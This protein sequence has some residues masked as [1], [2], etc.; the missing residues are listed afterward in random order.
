[1]DRV[2]NHEIQAME[3]S[4]AG[5][6]NLPATFQHNDAAFYTRFAQVNAF[7]NSRDCQGVDIAK[8]LRDLDGQVV[9]VGSTFLVFRT[10]A[11]CQ[12]DK[13]WPLNN[14]LN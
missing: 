10:V 11:P 12:P 13:L 6:F 8:Q 14:D 7:G 2:V 4:L 5:F 9:Q 1:M 3:D